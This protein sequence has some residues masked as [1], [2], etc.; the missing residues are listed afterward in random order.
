MSL[1]V[2]LAKAEGRVHVIQSDDA[3]IS[4]IAPQL[5]QIAPRAASVVQNYAVAAFTQKRIE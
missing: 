3:T 4:R 5:G 2:L 1:A